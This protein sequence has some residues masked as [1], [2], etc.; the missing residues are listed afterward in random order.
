M[1]TPRPD[2]PPTM[3]GVPRSSGRSSSSTAA[4][5]ASMSMCR[6]V[7]SESSALASDVRLVDPSCLLMS[8]PR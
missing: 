7:A 8:S 5:N 3:T 2:D 1:T 6:M 4:K